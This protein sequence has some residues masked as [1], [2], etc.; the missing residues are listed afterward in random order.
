MTGKQFGRWTVIGEPILTDRGERKWHCRCVCG[1]E[2]YVL[3]RSLKAGNSTSCGCLRR[4]ESSKA[5]RNDLAGKTFGELTVLR[6]SEKKHASGGIWWLCQCECGEE[7]EVPG[8]LLVTGRRTHCRARI[9]KTDCRSTDITGMRFRNLVALYPTEKR[10]KKGYVIWHCR[11][12][13]GN[14]IDVA[15]NNLMYTNLVSCGCRK[16]AHTSTLSQHLTRVAGTSLDM[17]KSKKVPVNNT[18]GHRGVY[19]IRGKYVAKINFQRKAYYLGAFDDIE[20]AVRARE[21]AEDQLYASAVD[22]YQQWEKKAAEDPQWGMDNPVRIR[23]TQ[24][25]DH[26]FHVVMLPALQGKH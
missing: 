12:D 16:K 14:E 15:S 22:F 8:T 3:E 10:D 19:L 21:A 13:C 26:Q 4:E 5:L 24:G 9:H 18:T 11:C 6:Q 20:D 23:V 25:M 1:T 2:R 7:Y 17:V